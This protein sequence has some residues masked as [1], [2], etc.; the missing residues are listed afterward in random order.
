MTVY[1]ER[2]GEREKRRNGGRKKRGKKV[3]TGADLHGSDEGTDKYRRK[4]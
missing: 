4:G 1:V 3:T 2:K